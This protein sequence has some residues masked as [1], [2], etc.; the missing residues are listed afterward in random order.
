MANEGLSNGATSAWEL[1]CDRLFELVPSAISVIDCEFRIRRVNATFRRMF[2]GRALGQHCYEVLTG[3]RRPCATCPL[4]RTFADGDSHQGEEVL[5]M[6]GGRG[7]RMAVQTSPIRDAAGRIVAG[8]EVA[9]DISRSVE[10]WQELALLGRAIAGLAHY[11]KNILTGLDGGVFVVEEG[12]AR[13]NDRQLRQGW[14]MVR[15]NVE[16]VSRLSR[17]Q[18]YCCRERTPRWEAIDPNTVVCEAAR[19]FAPRVVQEGMDLTVE[20]EGGRRFGL[21]DSEGLHNLVTNLLVNAL[22]ACRFDTDKQ[23]HW[24]SVK[25]MYDSGG[26]YVLEVADN[27]HGIPSDVNA[28]LFSDLLTTRGSAGTGLGLLVVYQVVTAHQGE[29]SVLSE[30]GLGSVFT[31]VLPVKRSSAAITGGESSASIP[32]PAEDDVTSGKRDVSTRP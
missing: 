9:T 7:I 14:E 16:R 29:V 19:L 17:D 2:G 25:S 18:L 22:E 4:A 32:A 21:F 13:G 27:G 5:E 11:I 20:L 6:A 3:R 1:P 31:V 24:I 12:L 30:E 15:R 28:H 26:R 23:Q 10:Q 8:I